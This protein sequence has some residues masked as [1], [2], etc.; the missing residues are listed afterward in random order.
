MDF[1]TEATRAHIAQVKRD[2]WPYTIGHVLATVAVVSVAWNSAD[3]A[4]LIRYGIVH[5]LATGVLALGFY[6]PLRSEP[7]RGL[8]LSTYAG[9][10][11]ANATL[12]SALLFDLVAA[13]DLAFTLTVGLALFAGVAGSFVTLG[14]HSTLIRVAIT[15]MIV[16][17]TITTFYLGH[18]ALAV[19]TIFF[20]ANV[21]L[22]GVWKLSIGQKEL[23]ALRFEAA[24]RADIAEMDAETDH[25]TG[26]SNRRAVER[27]EGTEL[28]AGAAALY[29]DVNKFKAIND[30][31]GHDVG[32]EILQIVAWRL[33]SAVS[34]KDIVARLGGDEFLVLIL[35]EQANA[36]EE[37]AER[38]SQRLQQPASVSDGSVL[39][40]SVAIGFSKTN[41][42][43]LKLDD[44]LRDSDKAMYQAK[45]DSREPVVESRL[46]G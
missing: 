37:V 44:L 31:Y 29:F 46:A 6:L 28:S 15:S 33:R 40:V 5:L 7:G 9:V 42:P 3:H 18:T 41:A 35:G 38:L 22:F 30:T 12:G 14:M 26:L 19:G 11:L 23:I 24:H 2:R 16:P 8:P 43:V 34:A 39:D 20:F 36:I 45:S 13:R 32:D 21:V 27:L 1:E 17:Y 25:L 10:V 4:G